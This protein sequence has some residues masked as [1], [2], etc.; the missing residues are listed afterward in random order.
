VL[1]S[2]PGEP[3][4]A[5]GRYDDL[6]SRYG[7]SAPA[8]GFALDLDNLQWTLRASD[9]ATVEPTPLRIAIGGADASAASIA[10]ALRRR[11]IV[12][13]TLPYHGQRR[14]LDFAKAWG[15]DATLV[16]AARRF[17]ITRASDGSD[18]TLARLDVT[19]LRTF[20]QRAGT[21]RK[22]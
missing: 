8:T 18:K 2:G 9:R 6:L 17:V 3:L 14:C 7:A 10:E 4:G 13:A 22:R 21:R 1:A 15:Y 11:G 16:P 5:G 19:A 20:V 12:A